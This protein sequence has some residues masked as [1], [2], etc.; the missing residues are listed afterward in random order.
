M[1]KIILSS[2][3]GIALFTGCS[4]REYYKPDKKHFVDKEIS[5]DKELNSEIKYFNKDV[6]TLKN[7][8]VLP[9][10]QK[11]PDGFVALDNNLAKKG[12][13]LRVGDREITFDTL[14]MTATQ[15]KNLV[16]ILFG[17]NH[18]EL[19]DLKQNKSIASANFGEFLATRKFI[20]KPYFYKDLLL[21]PTLN[22]KMI[23][24]DI[25]SKKIIRS[26]VVTQKDYFNNIIYL[27]VKKDSLIVASR[28]NILVITPNMIFNKPYNIKHVLVSDYN[29]YLFTIEGDVIKLNLVLKPLKK[30]SFKYAN[31]IAP[32]FVGKYIYFVENGDDSYLIRMNKNLEH[33]K[34]YPLDSPD[35]SEVNTFVKNGILYIGDKYIKLKDIK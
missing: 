18:F 8:E 15:N 10:K 20:A 31:I 14:I 16:A 35:L 23:V 1:K 21:I 17:D 12:Y 3:V 27:G 6:A 22:G 24:F 32:T 28:D 26:V 5:V 11:L 30:V 9:T 25:K 13:I 29:I 4:L 33:I 2:I 19:Y 34:V 7:G